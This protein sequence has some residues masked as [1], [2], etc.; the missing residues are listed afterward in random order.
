MWYVYTVPGVRPVTA[1]GV[2]RRPGKQRT[3]C[4]VLD[5]SLAPSLQTNQNVVSP[6]PSHSTVPP[7]R[8]LVGVSSCTRQLRASG[9]TVAGPGVVVGGSVVGG[10]VVGG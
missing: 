7:S 3:T 10:S 1:T 5:H 6:V 9:A 8:P 4:G 2:Q